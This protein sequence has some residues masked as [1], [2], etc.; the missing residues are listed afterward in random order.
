MTKK[1]PP[2]TFRHP[3]RSF[4]T[5]TEGLSAPLQPL[6][7]QLGFRQCAHI[8][9]CGRPDS[10]PLQR[11]GVSHWRYEQPAVA[12]EADKSA[13][14]KMINA[15][16]Q[17]EAVLPVEAL[18]IRAIPPGLAMAC[19]QNAQDSRP[20]SL[21]SASQPQK[22]ADGTIPDPVEQGSPMMRV[23][24]EWPN[25]YGS[26]CSLPDAPWHAICGSHG[27]APS[28]P[29]REQPKAR[30]PAHCCV[31]PNVACTEPRN[32]SPVSVAAR[33]VRSFDSV[34]TSAILPSCNQLRWRAHFRSAYLVSGIRQRS[35]CQVPCRPTLSVIA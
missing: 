20:Q 25:R 14:K 23:T 22:P 5:W 19:P 4:T 1:E 3:S 28:T 11:S 33:V 9:P 24:E 10:H 17:Q 16:S 31:G 27:E 2:S 30:W 29:P 35:A 32:G 13:I 15:R 8:N 12:F 7:W 21:D 26:S 6:V 34:W 18:F